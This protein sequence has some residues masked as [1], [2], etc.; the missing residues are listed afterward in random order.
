MS[1]EVVAVIEL[2]SCVR[3]FV[4]PWTA[5]HQPSLSIIISWSLPKFMSIESVIPSNHLFLCCPL[6]LFPSIF[7]SIR[8]F[9]NELAVHIRQSKYWSF[10]ISPSGLISFRTN[11]FDLLAVPL[12][13]LPQHCSS[14][15]SI[16][17]KSDFLIVPVSHLSE[18]NIEPNHQESFLFFFFEP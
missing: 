17:W 7:S 6:L 8:V 16:L 12:K 18:D 14:K 13:S 11:W 3:L 5:A 9:S 1:E 15:T 10:S 2:L 4:T